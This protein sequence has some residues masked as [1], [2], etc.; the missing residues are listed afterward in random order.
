MSGAF[1]FSLSQSETTIDENN[2]GAQG[3]TVGV[4]GATVAT[5]GI[6]ANSNANVTVTDSGAIEG[7]IALGQRA[8]DSAD[9]S[10]LVAQQG[11][12]EQVRMVSETAGG[13]ISNLGAML[14]RGNEIVA[15]ALTGKQVTAGP[16]KWIPL[17][18]VA[19]LVL[20]VVM[21]RRQ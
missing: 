13:A 12:A 10:A 18:A 9:R 2:I 21:V 6:A 20:V 1:G 11:A 3:S 4:E 7:A 16:E 19:G 14:S 17:A 15:S 5:G 8:L